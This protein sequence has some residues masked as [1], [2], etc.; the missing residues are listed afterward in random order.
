MTH[1]LVVEQRPLGRLMPLLRDG[2]FEV[3]VVPDVADLI[4]KAYVEARPEAVLLETTHLDAAAI[5]LCRFL[6][7]FATVP[8]AVVCE[9]GDEGDIVGAYAAGAAAVVLEPVGSHELIARV[10]ALLRRVQVTVV[11]DDGVLTVGPVVLDRSCR[12]LTVEGEPLELPRRE[13]EIAEVLMRNAGTVVPRRQLL[14]ELWGGA[15]RDSKSLDVQVGRLR[16]RLAAVEG[17]RRILTVRGMGYRFLTDADLERT[18]AT[19]LD[20]V[21]DPS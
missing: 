20:D 11:D 17:R 16:S 14:L 10:R 15:S 4:E 2:G 7:T 19:Q 3:E 1:V 8:F 21:S 6:D 12:R 13:F 9:L 5:E 18:A